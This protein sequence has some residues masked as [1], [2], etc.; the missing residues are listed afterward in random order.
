MIHKKNNFNERDKKYSDK[1]KKNLKG[2]FLISESNISDSNF[3]Q[4]VILVIDHKRMGSFGLIV[5]KHSNY[6]LSNVSPLDSQNDSQPLPLYFGGPVQPE[7]IFALHSEMPE[8]HK[9]SKLGFEVSP[10]LFFEPYIGQIEYCFKKEFWLNTPIDDRPKIHLFL[11]YTGWGAGQL[12]SEIEEG[13]WISHDAHPKIIFLPKP[14]EIWKAALRDK[15]GIYKIFANSN[16][17]P[18]LN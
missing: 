3:Y 8:N 11:G 1:V 5:N 9:M 16:Q 2:K 14:E 10:G 12:E 18:S 7:Y 6:L 17:K 13:T 15:G 4:T